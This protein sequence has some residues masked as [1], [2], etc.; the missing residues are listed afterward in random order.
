M[1]CF[2]SLKSRC[3]L[4]SRTG[5]RYLL[6]R[7]AASA[8]SQL[9][10]MYVAAF[11][12]S[13]YTSTCN[14]LGKPFNPLLHETFE[15][16]EPPTHAIGAGGSGG[17]GGGGGYRFLAEQ[18]G[19]HPPVSAAYAES[20]THSDVP[21][22]KSISSDADEQLRAGDGKVPRQQYTRVTCI[23]RDRN[24][25]L[26]GH[27]TDFSAIARF[28]IRF[29]SATINNKN[30]SMAERP[31]IVVGDRTEAGAPSRHWR[32]VRADVEILGGLGAEDEDYLFHG[33]RCR[34]E[35]RT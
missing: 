2:F 20:L 34:R 5:H 16:V 21:A 31:V 10:L 13:N 1:F 17:S 25:T 29:H 22:R 7:A 8:D 15:Y 27:L 33:V 35:W 28:H 30:C 3:L 32:W 26:P 19:H 18:V 11:A 4:I 23:M 24:A 6:D 9:R 14:R 12:M